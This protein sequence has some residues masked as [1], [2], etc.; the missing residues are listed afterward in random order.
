MAKRPSSSPHHNQLLAA[1][2]TGDFD[3][4]DSHLTPLPM[5][6][7]HVCE[8]PN[9][10]IRHVYF[11]EEGIA[12]VVAVTK[13]D[14]QIE[15]GII[16]PEG[17]TGLAVVMGNDRSPHSTYVQAA[18][19]AHRIT[20]P[21]LR[22]AMESSDTLQPMLLK[23]V[24]TFMTQ[25]AHTAI[26]NGR[27]TLEERLAR[28]LL[29]AHDRLESDELPLTHELVS[30]MLGVRRAGVTTTVH[31]LE[32]NGLIKSQRGKISVIDREGL[33]KVAGSY[34][35]VPEAEWQRLMT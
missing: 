15:I 8:E 35:G 23:F 32:C 20:V 34:Y 7:Q 24:Q 1:L 30:L 21:H 29:M 2:S 18:G 12:S 13:H 27:A 17:M 14:K 6:V 16:G 4:L 10:P 28:W 9:K 22:D 11:M 19:A 5:K 33:E 31:S 3:L 26:A 25:T